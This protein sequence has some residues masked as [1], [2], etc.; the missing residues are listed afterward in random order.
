M[1]CRETPATATLRLSGEENLDGGIDWLHLYFRDTR[2]LSLDLFSLFLSNRFARK[3][4]RNFIIDLLYVTSYT[5][6]FFVKRTAI[7]D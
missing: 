7:F 2:L 4:T 3:L 5:L 6:Y 1:D